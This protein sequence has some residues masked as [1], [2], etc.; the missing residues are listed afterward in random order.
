MYN[1]QTQHSR[2]KTLREKAQSYRPMTAAIEATGSELPEVLGSKN[3][4]HSQQKLKNSTFY[5]HGGVQ[6]ER[7]PVSERK[8]TR[9]EISYIERTMSK[10]KSK[11]SMRSD[12][13]FGKRYSKDLPKTKIDVID[14]YYSSI[15]INDEVEKVAF[16]N[17]Y[18]RLIDS[19]SKLWRALEAMWAIPNV[20]QQLVTSLLER[21]VYNRQNRDPALLY[22][23][24]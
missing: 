24:S 3:I 13:K 15:N 19:A 21:E 1:H 4:L 23:L 9:D 2:T 12:L 18:R 6:L 10:P 14:N 16:V 5:K 20:E 8:L 7:S 17:E 22:K 11:G